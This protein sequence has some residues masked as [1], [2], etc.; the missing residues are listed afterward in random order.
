MKHFSKRN[1]LLAAGAVLLLGAIA[2]TVY[3][4]T[5]PYV[6]T[7]ELQV[8]AVIYNFGDE[9][10]QVSLVSTSASTTESMDRHYSYYIRPDLL[11]SWKE[12]PQTALGRQSVLPWPDHIDIRSLTDNEN[13]TY[14]VEATLVGTTQ[15]IDPTS[16]A[17]EVPVRFTVS[18]GPDGWQISAYEAVV[19]P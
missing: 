4:S 6:P 12:R 13:G 8:R 18:Q 5:R 7:N 19:T 2:V 3:F 9:L 17:K 1:V 14:T 16:A 11:S 15:G 10:S